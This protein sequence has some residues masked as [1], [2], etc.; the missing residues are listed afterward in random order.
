MGKGVIRCSVQYPNGTD[1]V[2]KY[3]LG[4]GGYV[5]QVIDAEVIHFMT[6]YAP[7]KTGLMMDRAVSAT[8]LGSG[9]VNIPGP[10]AHFQYVG[11][12]RTTE[13]G[14]VFAKKGEAKPVL[15]KRELSHEGSNNP[16]AQKEWFEVMKR[17]HTKDIL[18]EAKRAAKRGKP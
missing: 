2:N 8:V 10:Y 9:V 18:D 15:T 13:D 14:R 3:R 17:N 11:Y 5:Q 1:F 16:A 12:V 4:K 6:P 7:K